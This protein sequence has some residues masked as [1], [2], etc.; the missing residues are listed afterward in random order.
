MIWIICAVLSAAMLALSVHSYL[1]KNGGSLRV[2]YV[3]AC[4]FIAT[5]IIY[6]PAFLTS[7]DLLSGMIGNF[8]H[9]LQVI[10]MDADIM[11]FYDVINAGIGNVV[12]TKIYIVLLGVLHIAL[13]TISAVTAVTVLLR[14]FSSMQLFFAN[15]GKEPIFI[16]SELNERSMQLAKSLEKIKCGILFSG[17]GNESLNMESNRANKCIF[18]EESISELNIK[19]KKK[20]NI[21]FFCISDNEDE[22][23]SY[24]L[25][26]IE[27]FLSLS[28]T[29]QEHIHIYLFSKH[30]DFSTFIDSADKGMLDIQCINEYEM[31]VYNL[32]DKYPLFQFTKDSIHVLLHGLSYVNVVALK[33]IAWCGQ[34]SGFSMRISV[35]GVNIGKQISEL[36]L[37]TPGLFA[38]RYSI[39]FYD[40]ENEKEVIDAVERNCAD[41]NYIIVSDDSD[42]DT[43]NYGILLRR[44]FYKLS[45]DYD[46]CPPVFCHIKEPSK[47]NIVDNLATAESNPKRKMSYDLIPFGSLSEVYSYEKLVDSDLEKLAKNVHLAYEEIFSD[48]QI[49]VKEALRRYNT[50]EV[51]KR[52][53]RANALHIRYKLNL[54]GL[55]YSDESGVCCVEMRDY[56]TE[57]SVE[58]LAIS[59]HDRWMAFLE[60]E[61]WIPAAKEDVYSYRESGISRGRHNC[62]LLKMHP[63]ICEYEK[64]EDLSMELEG[65]DTSVYDR[66][67][68]LRIPDILGDKWNA[69]GKKYKIIILNKQSGGYHHG[70]SE[71]ENDRFGS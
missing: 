71:H 5:Y 35:A 13:P 42:N 66:E 6:I 28:D 23:L 62:P 53:N 43:I 51:N 40:C 32:L 17:S 56:Y 47:Y 55:D 26:L 33:A 29:E 70:E 64:L 68:I 14:C 19:I 46:Y 52:S 49:D 58:K 3:L 25:Q 59:E 24:A 27:K 60:T 10:S 50:F 12:V 63:Y 61:G 34:L 18:K 1:D 31:L 57:A 16:F 7:Y 21:H 9:V 20:K 37:Y 39:D 30:Q 45:K 41:A 22:S 2:V 69:A 11:E 15:S 67:L 65:K 4:L 8:V 44:L 54:L 36:E 38:D 48:G